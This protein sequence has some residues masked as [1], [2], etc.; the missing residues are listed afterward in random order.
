MRKFKM[1]LFAVCLLCLLSCSSALAATDVIASGD[2]GANGDNVTW[3]L[4]ADGVLTISGSGE[5]KDYSTHCE[6]YSDEKI[7]VTTDAPWFQYVSQIES[8][9]INDSIVSVGGGT[10]A[11]LDKLVRVFIPNSVITIG[12]DAFASC[13]NLVNL[14]IPDSVIEI[15]S[16]AFLGCNNLTEIT[17]PDSVK[18][19]G[20][21]TFMYCHSLTE[22]TIP[23]NITNI[24][25]GTFSNCKNLKNFYCETDNI[26]YYSEKGILYEKN[27][28]N[29]TL[30][31]YPT[32]RKETTYKI[33]DNVDNIASKAFQGCYNLT[34]LSLPN[35]IKSI[36][37]S[38]F[39]DCNNLIAITIPNSVKEIGPGTFW[40]C[41]NLKTA[42]LPNNLTN[43]ADGLFGGCT[44]LTEIT[45]PDS[46]TTIGN[47]AFEGCDSLKEIMIP[48]NVINISDNVFSGCNN[49]KNFYCEANNINY[50][51]EQGILYEKKE[52]GFVLKAYPLGRTNEI[53][54]IKNGVIGIAEN[55]FSTCSKLVEII[56]PNSVT[57]IGE[58]AFSG[59]NHLTKIT[60]PNSITNIGQG[61]FS[62]CN[63]L[64]D[65]YYTGTE[66][67][68]RTI[69]IDRL[70]NDPLFNATIH[71]NYTPSD[72]IDPQNSSVAFES[73]NMAVEE[74][75]PVDIHFDFDNPSA[76]T[77]AYVWFTESGRN[78]A[79]SEVTAEDA[80]INQTNNN[81][82]FTIENAAAGNTYAFSFP[83]AG[84][85]V[86]RAAF[87]DPME[88][89]ENGTVGTV[90]DA[91]TNVENM[92]SRPSNQEDVISVIHNIHPENWT[93]R[94]T[95]DGKELSGSDAVKVK[96]NDKKGTDVT[97]QLLSEDG[98]TIKGH[99]LM[100]T[101]DSVNIAT[102]K[103]TITTNYKGEATFTITGTQVGTYKIFVTWGNANTITIPVTVEKSSG[104][105]SSGGSSGGGSS[106][107]SS[108]ISNIVV[109][110]PDS[111]IKITTSSV[112]NQIVKDAEATVAKD[113]H[114]QVIGG[115]NCAIS[116]S[117]KENGNTVTGFDDPVKVT[118][119]VSSSAF[120]E[121][122][123]SSKLTLAKVT[124]DET[125]QTVFTYM[126]GNYDANSKTFT[127]Y[128]DEPGD[129]ILIEDSDI[130]K[131]ELQI[132]SSNSTHNG[133]AI[134]NDVAPIIYNNRTMVP[135]RFLAET[136]G[137]Q[138]DWNEAARTV[139]LLIDGV[140]MS[141]TI[142][143]AIEGF[144]TA[145][146]I[147]QERTMVPIRYIAEQLNA[148]VIYA[149][150]TQKIIV[151]K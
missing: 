81:G 102:N 49:L 68:W 78:I 36:E 15:G 18:K 110:T 123:D 147:H 40:R 120:N 88:L 10:F 13:N 9:I 42:T 150:D 47:S 148:N 108:N 95:A 107:N 106:N 127:A 71:Y 65:V 5:M 60:I 32:G 52:N 6:I 16:S 37:E 151:V 24:G 48:N 86:V 91:F 135:L 124:K 27:A 66:E 35:N 17:I 138:V 39:T 140:Q 132:G 43:I 63:N 97:V 53:Y 1:I 31:A 92:L 55:A 7:L 114:V 122:T 19:I 28:T 83:S 11:G 115:K 119:P 58:Y 69:N 22:I 4:T 98:K 101:N 85:Y 29:I 109:T 87:N 104:G 117:A 142:D 74:N 51:A 23:K 14:L 64:T 50:H 141:M 90:N 105:S 3:E 38:A 73:A 125:G 131:I 54:T 129:Y 93:M 111:S 128:V 59:C 89:L 84:E 79:A 144:D 41:K 62:V 75:I 82:V 143:E 56:L 130:Q 133:S 116:I 145:P 149:P 45:I 103:Q 30:K 20:H 118:I 112:G 44:N 94:V 25:N 100:I 26:K 113:E 21:D 134:A 8:V 146:I 96:K 72:T 34:T 2:C 121:V 137:A 61:I 67:E 57:Q 46:V 99:T 77:T 139:T 33:L 76:T 12:H 136:L 80:A 126:G 70:G